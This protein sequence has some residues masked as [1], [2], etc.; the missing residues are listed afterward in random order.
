[1]CNCGANKTPPQGMGVRPSAAPSAAQRA[2]ERAAAE[3]AA[4]AAN[5]STSRIGP[6]AA[7]TSSYAY[8]SPDGAAHRVGSLLEARAAAA[9]SGGDVL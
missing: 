2:A 9:R 6:A 5:P 7:R 4:K 1:M 3:A 8:R